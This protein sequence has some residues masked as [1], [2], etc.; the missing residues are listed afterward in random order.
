MAQNKLS[1]LVI[2]KQSSKPVI[3][4][5]ISDDLIGSNPPEMNDGIVKSSKY[6]KIEAELTAM[7][8]EPFPSLS[9]EI[10]HSKRWDRMCATFHWDG[11]ADLLPE[12]RFHRLVGVIPENFRIEKMAGFVWLELEPG[13]SVDSFLNQ[14]RSEDVEHR[15]LEIDASL[16]RAGFFDV[17]EKLISARR[18]KG[19]PGDFSLSRQALVNSKCGTKQI[20]DAKLLFI[21]HGAYCDCQVLQSVEPA[22]SKRHAATG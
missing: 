15:E 5:K 11:F 6:S 10:S 16:R 13:E 3:Q 7:L 20:T 18:N 19:C 17:L 2:E 14:P 9:V 12:E 8:E 22:F 4:S 1:T 21:R